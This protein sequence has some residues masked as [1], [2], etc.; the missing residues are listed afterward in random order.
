MPESFQTMPLQFVCMKWGSKYLAQ[1][2]N[3]LYRAVRKLTPGALKFYCLTDQAEGID[4][5]VTVLPIPSLPV[6]GDQVL[7]RGWRKLT[8][9]S[10]ELAAIAGPTLFLDLDMVIVDSL[11]P[12]FAHDDAFRVIK[13]YKR[14]RY[15]NTWSGNTSVF[16]YR[17]GR[18]YGVY[19]RLRTLGAEVRVRYRNEQEFMSDCMRV[20][21]ELNYWPPDW[22]PSFK[23]HCVPAFP[24]SLWQAPRLPVGAKVLV[25]HGRP[26]P[27]EA[28]R[29]DGAKW[30]RPTRPAP[31]L[32]PFLESPE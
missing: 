3:R 24:F 6:L 8:L 15:R 27:E 28:L 13:D 12:F 9:F 16:F 23:Y 25:F 14:F 17:A 5:Q 31:W 26:K 11:A 2:V 22:C 10:P 20:R 4:P 30:Y 29:G 19:E 7:D 1:D 32:A 18:G 21:G